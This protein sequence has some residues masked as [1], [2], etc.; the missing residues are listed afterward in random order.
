M[1]TGHV[2][3]SSSPSYRLGM[4]KEDHVRNPTPA[5]VAT[6]MLCLTACS[7]PEYSRGSDDPSID[8]PAMSTRL[9]RADLE[10]ALGH[11]M[12]GFAN[13]E[14]VRDVRD[15]TPNIA[16]LRIANDTS[17]HISSALDNL[18][19]SVETRLVADG[20]FNVIDNSKLTADALMAERLRDLG[21]S[22]DDKTVAALGKEYGIH[23]FING[24]VGDTA[25]KTNDARRVQYFLF[26][27]VTDVATR[28]IVF[29]DE[30]AVTKKVEG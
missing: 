28:R 22:V 3:L 8:L 2:P 14:F 24:R 10:L 23:Y 1:G 9:D 4:T 29:Q 6:L 15:E 16:I 13:S 12:E 26:M 17:E 18:L 27:R 21:D 30:V 7:S 5:L 20:G 11:W 19:N 25:E